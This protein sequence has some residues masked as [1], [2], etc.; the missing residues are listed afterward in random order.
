MLW[1]SFSDHV[2]TVSDEQLVTT[3]SIFCQN[4]QAMHVK[5]WSV[6]PDA[7]TV[8]IKLFSGVKYR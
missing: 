1:M 7:I 6:P 8:S 4:L 2:D 3:W 5:Q